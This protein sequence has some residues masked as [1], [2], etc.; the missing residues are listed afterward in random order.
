ME[1]YDTNLDIQID[2]DIKNMIEKDLKAYKWQYES[3]Y[4]GEDYSNYYIIYTH[5][6][7]SNI[8]EESN[9]QSILNFL[10]SKNCQFE[11][12]RFTNWLVG[13]HEYI[14]IEESNI[15]SLLIAVDILKQLENYPIFDEDNYYQKIEDRAEEL[16]ED[17]YL[18]EDTLIHEI[19]IYKGRVTYQGRIKESGT[20]KNDEEIEESLYDYLQEIAEE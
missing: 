13:W 9:Y 8:M 14:M 16:F 5:N 15:D 10:E 17:L 20:L 11:Q 19:E 2:K 3:N 6:R 1:N 12:I 7:D 4:I 18:V